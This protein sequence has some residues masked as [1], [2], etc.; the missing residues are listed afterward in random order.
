MLI[1]SYGLANST[2]RFSISNNID[3]NNDIRWLYYPIATLISLSVLFYIRHVAIN[4]EGTKMTYF[5]FVGN[6][7][8]SLISDADESN[9][10]E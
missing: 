5:E 3:A 6:H 9:A 7:R 1:T 8:Y 10:K 4:E 2:L